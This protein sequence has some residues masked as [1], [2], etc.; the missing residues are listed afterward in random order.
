MTTEIGEFEAGV[1]GHMRKDLPIV[2]II[3]RPNVGKSTLFNRICGKKKAI[4]E[5]TPGITRDR[6][7]CECEYN[8][9][10]FVICDTGGLEINSKDKTSLS[11]KKQI[12]KTIEESSAIIFLFDVEDGLLPEDEE[13]V[14]FLRKANKP[15]FYVVNKVD[16]EKKMRALSEFYALG[17]EKIYAI[18]ALHGRNV[19]E[20]LDS[21]TH[22]LRSFS[23]PKNGEEDEEEAL[24]IAIIG[25]PNTGK[26]SIVNGLIGDERVIVSEEPGTTRDAIDTMISFNNRKLIIVDTAGIRKKSKVKTIVEVKS[27]ASAIKTIERSHV[28]NL[29]LDATEGLGNQ[30]AKITHTA[31]NYGKGVVLVVNKWDLMEGKVKEEDYLKEIRIKAPHASFCPVVFVSALKRKNLEKI[32]EMDIEVERELR[33]RIDTPQLNKDLE[34]IMEI[35]E[36]PS[37]QGKRIRIYYGTQVG[38]YPPSFVFFSNFPELIPQNYKKY[39]ER[40]L[41][42]RYGFL[43]TPLRLKFRKK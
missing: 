34:R 25:R 21:L 7:Y 29:I 41:R 10:K 35:R 26:S 9:L 6:N 37:P 38:I 43:G 22:T 8:G 17:E 36:P 16:T 2:G 33:K 39:L 11:V 32:L 4:V 40:S 31:L 14:K 20:L 18:S 30:E 12:E 42:E 19:S 3:G 28:V 15:I 13:A 27:I 24:K 1:L 23:P 5:D